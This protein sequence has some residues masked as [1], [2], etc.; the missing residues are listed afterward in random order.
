MIRSSRSKVL[1]PLIAEY[2][3]RLNELEQLFEVLEKMRDH[4]AELIEEESRTAGEAPPLLM[5]RLT[6]LNDALDQIGIQG[7][8][9]VR[10]IRALGGSY[11][12]R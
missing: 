5:G 8:V 12:L 4:A 10:K 6:A 2:E 9:L 1:N 7:H 11:N 3:A